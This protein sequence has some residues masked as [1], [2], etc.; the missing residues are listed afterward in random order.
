M[1]TTP[2]PPKMKY[3]RLGNT[4]MRVSEICLGAMNFGWTTDEQT[5]FQI[6]D[7]FAELGGNFIDTADFYSL[8]NQGISETIIG[9][10]L[11][12][13]KRDDFVIATKGGLF[14]G[15]NT[16]DKGSS[17]KHISAAIEASLKRLQT[18]YIDLYQIHSFDRETPIEET[19][20]TLNDFIRA[21]KIRYIGCSNYRGHQLIKAKYLAKELLLQ[22]YI[23]L[24]AEYNLLTREVEW[25]VLE[26]VRENNMA[27][28]VW[29]PLKSGYLAG[30]YSKEMKAAPNESRLEALDKI[31]FKAYSLETATD[32]TW[33]VVDAVKEVADRLG[34]SPSQVSLRWLMQKGI[35]TSPIVGP[36]DMKQAEDNFAAF[37]WTL[38]EEDMQK[39]D[40][41][42]NPPR[43]P[44]PYSWATTASFV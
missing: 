2:Q 37:T 31:G 40:K 33:T 25:E 17:R 23:C 35:V 26:A 14:V 19:L 11:Q 7:R 39:L 16:N 28:I 43:V 22:P 44:Y 3:K 8:P 27:L 42:S 18:S 36:R 41:V 10:W 29:G 13:K 9:K 32:Y 38:S 30:K 12:T 20:A 4:G 1:A 34:K 24:Q 6:L 21:G 5:S 15:P